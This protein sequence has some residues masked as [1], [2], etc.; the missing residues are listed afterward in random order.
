MFLNYLLPSASC[1]FLP[2]A[3]ICLLLIPISPTFPLRDSIHHPSRLA[4]FYHKVMCVHPVQ[5]MD[6]D[7]EP[8]P[9]QPYTWPQKGFSEAALAL[10]VRQTSKQ[11]VTGAN[12]GAAEILPRRVTGGS[13]VGTTAKPVPAK[14]LVS[15]RLPASRLPFLALSV[16]LSPPLTLGAD[17]LFQYLIGSKYVCVHAHSVVSSVT[18]W[19]VACQAPQSMGF[20][21]QTHV[22]YVSSF[23]RW[24]LYH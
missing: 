16:F 8:T 4:C 6:A 1:F 19:A 22:S 15:L 9:R 23:G 20:R 13:G 12:A 3:H 14:A 7:Q 18:P 17:L 10:W 21:N 24:I 11:L 5:L 2:S